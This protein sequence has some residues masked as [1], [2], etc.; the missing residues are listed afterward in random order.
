MPYFG[1]LMTDVNV[2]HPPALHRV[3]LFMKY[4]TILHVAVS[5][6]FYRGLYFVR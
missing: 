2:G 1:L 4:T 3:A 5:Y 6:A